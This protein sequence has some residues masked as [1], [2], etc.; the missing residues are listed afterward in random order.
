MNK[1]AIIDRLIIILFSIMIIVKILCIYNMLC[2]KY[3]IDTTY[4]KS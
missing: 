2:K 1:T 4:N 3:E